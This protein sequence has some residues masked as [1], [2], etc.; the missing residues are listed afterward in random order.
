MINEQSIS[1]EYNGVY[2]Q[3]NGEQVIG[4]YFIKKQGGTLIAKSIGYTISRRTILCTFFDSGLNYEVIKRSKGYFL[5][6]NEGEIVGSFKLAWTRSTIELRIHNH[7][8]MFHS[9]DFGKTYKIRR[10]GEEVGV[11]G[12]PNWLEEDIR[13]SL[14]KSENLEMIVL[15]VLGIAYDVCTSFFRFFK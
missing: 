10:N 8:Y 11:I 14:L 5:I 1:D 15:V 2:L 6:L 9:N 13:I 3:K 7:I 4:S 12:S